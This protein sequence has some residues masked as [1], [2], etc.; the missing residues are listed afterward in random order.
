MSLTK[1]Q[2][3][4]LKHVEQVTPYR[5]RLQFADGHVTEV[6]F[7]PFIQQ[8]QHPSIRK[9]LDQNLFQQYRIEHGDLMWGD[10]DLVFPIHQ[11]YDGKI[12]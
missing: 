6:D 8:A 1:T 10:F 4:Q 11:L 9:Y 3:L 2:V 12:A 5:L 7:E